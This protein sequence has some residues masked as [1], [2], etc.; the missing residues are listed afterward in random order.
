MKRSARLIA[1]HDFVEKQLRDVI[2][3]KCK[4]TLATYA[5]V[6]TADLSDACQGFQNIEEAR[7]RFNVTWDLYNAKT[8]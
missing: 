3:D 7:R 8:P 6:C 4:A 2:C 5:D 1:E